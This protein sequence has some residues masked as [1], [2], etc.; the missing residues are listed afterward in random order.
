MILSSLH[1]PRQSRGF[2]RLRLAYEVRVQQYMI[3]VPYLVLRFVYVLVMLEVYD[4]NW[5]TLLRAPLRPLSSPYV[6]VERP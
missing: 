2:C 5:L 4:T 1:V 6:A 3:T